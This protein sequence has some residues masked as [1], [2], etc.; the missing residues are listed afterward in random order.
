MR[1]RS[2]HPGRIQTKPRS[3][4]QLLE[5]WHTLQIP[6][7]MQAWHEFPPLQRAL[8]VFALALLF[9]YFSLMDYSGGGTRLAVD[10]V[11]ALV[12]AEVAVGARRC[13]AAARGACDKSFLQQVGLVDFAD[14]IGLFAHRRGETLEHDRTAVQLV[15]DGGEDRAVHPVKAAGVDLQQ[16][17]RADRDFAGHRSGFVDL[18]EVAHP[19]QQAVG[20]ARCPACAARDLVRP[21]VVEADA[22]QARRTR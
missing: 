7:L 8:T 5:F 9:G 4:K 18:G 22:K 1:I 21:C 17:E 12:A 13:Y 6:S 14:G 19:A 2:S 11:A 16:L 3:G 15:D 20:D 10:G